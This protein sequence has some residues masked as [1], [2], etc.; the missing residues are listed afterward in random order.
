MKGLRGKITWNNRGK[1][2][3][4]AFNTPAHIQNYYLSPKMQ[5]IKQNENYYESKG[6]MMIIQFD[7]NEIKQIIS[8]FYLYKFYDQFGNPFRINKNIV[9]E[10]DTKQQRDDIN[11]IVEDMIKNINKLAAQKYNLLKQ[12]K[13]KAIIAVLKKVKNYLS[14]N[15]VTWTYNKSNGKTRIECNV[16]RKTFLKNGRS[17][18]EGKM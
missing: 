4:I 11:D 1:I 8:I 14:I 10:D 12:N 17:I 16:Y 13:K 6:N 15:G 2:V 9:D 5:E 7:M 3:E 18:E